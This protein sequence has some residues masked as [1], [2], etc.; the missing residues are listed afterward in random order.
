MRIAAGTR[1]LLSRRLLLPLWHAQRR[2][3]PSR[4]AVAS[5]FTE[6]LRF[7]RATA[8]WSEDEKVHW[9]IERLR[10]TLRRAYRDAPYYRKLLDDAGF[11]PNSDFDLDEFAQLPILE[12]EAVRELGKDMI[13][14]SVRSDLLKKDAT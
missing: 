6:G 4:R 5:A 13:S 3:R 7:R 10:F 1:E 11:D 14:R 8:A 12:R 9:I 2:L